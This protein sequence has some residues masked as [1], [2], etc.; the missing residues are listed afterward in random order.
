[1]SVKQPYC[2]LC[3]KPLKKQTETHY[4]GA[5]SQGMSFGT[6][7]PEDPQTRAE[8]QRYIN[9]RIVSSRRG[10]RGMVVTAWD[11][12][13]YRAEEE[14]F[15]TLRCAA[16]YGRFAVVNRPDLQTQKYADALRAALDQGVG[17]QAGE[18]ADHG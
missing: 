1:M 16:S 13:T 11:G 10:Y 14:Y 8:A 3:G 15:C 7:H 9:Q 12:E 5:A 4:F 18:G 6:S 2:R 17:M